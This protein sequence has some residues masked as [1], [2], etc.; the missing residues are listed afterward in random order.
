MYAYIKGTMAHLVWFGLS[1][2]AIPQLDRFV[3]DE[4][5]NAVQPDRHENRAFR[6]GGRWQDI[7]NNIYDKYQ[8]ETAKLYAT[9]ARLQRATAKF[10]KTQARLQEATSK[11]QR[12]TANLYATDTR[13]QA[14]TAKLVA[15]ATEEAVH[16]RARNRSMDEDAADSILQEPTA[17]NTTQNVTY[18][19]VMLL[20]MDTPAPSPSPE[21]PSLGAKAREFGGRADRMI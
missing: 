19:E 14:A 13:L 4:K 6:Q 21:A 2:L 10:Y 9:E 1:I 5:V 15:A 11:F 20:E 12:A 8:S 18:Q 17:T 7:V 3:A 16:D